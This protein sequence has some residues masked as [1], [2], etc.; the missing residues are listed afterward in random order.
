MACRLNEL[1]PSGGN[2]CVTVN[3]REGGR[4]NVFG[5]R[6]LNDG[7]I[8]RLT[9]HDVNE[10]YSLHLAP[11]G[12]HQTIPK[13]SYSHTY[14]D[15][16]PVSF[17]SQFVPVITTM[18]AEPFRMIERQSTSGSSNVG[19]IRTSLPMVQPKALKPDCDDN[20]LPLFAARKVNLAQSRFYDSRWSFRK[21][22]LTF[23]WDL[24]LHLDSYTVERFPRGIEDPSGWLR[25]HVH[26]QTSLTIP[27]LNC[28]YHIPVWRHLR[29]IWS[30]IM[31]WTLNLIKHKNG[32]PPMMVDGLFVVWFQSYV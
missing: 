7:F 2:S 14:V 9:L 5:E 11:E 15:H 12:H 22:S 20:S 18:L 29:T 21:N 27:S 23:S 25:C 16:L 24:H 6:S 8:R 17:R 30:K 4:I 13:V 31:Y 32:R 19:R 10:K 26:N 1:K 28:L 3:S